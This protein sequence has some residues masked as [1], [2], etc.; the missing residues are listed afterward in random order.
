M[1]V[2]REIHSVETWEV[3]DGP[4]RERRACCGLD[5]FTPVQDEQNSQAIE[6]AFAHH[7]SHRVRGRKLAGPVE[8]LPRLH[9]C[10]CR[11]YELTE[12]AFGSATRGIDDPVFHERALTRGAES[13]MSHWSGGGNL[14]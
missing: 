8:P 4:P 6:V 1:G 12:M 3:W 14:V 2:G 11:I 10:G 5:F 13:R 7:Y 9:A